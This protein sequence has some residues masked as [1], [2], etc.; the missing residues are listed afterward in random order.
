MASLSPAA[1]TRNLAQVRERIA[2]AERRA[3]RLPG[4]VTLVAATKYLP[5][6]DIPTLV[7]SGCR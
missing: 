7:R 5:A 6:A 3:G 1:V 4:S 2:A